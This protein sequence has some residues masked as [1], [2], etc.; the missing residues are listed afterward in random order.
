MVLMNLIR[1]FLK[2]LQLISHALQNKIDQHVNLNLC[3][4]VE[5]TV[6]CNFLLQSEKEEKKDDS[7]IVSQDSFNDVDDDDHQPDG[8]CKIPIL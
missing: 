6:F 1:G 3:L 5:A 2:N 4:D 7:A 8:K